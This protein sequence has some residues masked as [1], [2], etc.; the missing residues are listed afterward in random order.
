MVDEIVHESLAVWCESQMLSG[1]PYESIMRNL[2]QALMRTSA[3]WTGTPIRAEHDWLGVYH[4]WDTSEW[5]EL[6]SGI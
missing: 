1:T 6:V 5:Q 2:Q 3:Q 4:F